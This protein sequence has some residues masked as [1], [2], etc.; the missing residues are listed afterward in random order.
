MS[1]GQSPKLKGVL[2]NTPID[3]ADVCNILQRPADSNGIAMLKLKRKLQ[4][5]DHFYLNLKD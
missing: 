4:Y 5:R 1:K 2:F 3:V